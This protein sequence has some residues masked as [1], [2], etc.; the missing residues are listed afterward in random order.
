MIAGQFSTPS[1]RER[2]FLSGTLPM[3]A[4]LL[5]SAPV[6]RSVLPTLIQLSP[7]FVDLKRKLPP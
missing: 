6:V 1:C 3:I 2:V 4:S 5:R 7:R